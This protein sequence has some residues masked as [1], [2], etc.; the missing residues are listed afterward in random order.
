MDTRE[1]VIGKMQKWA[2]LA[3]G[4]TAL[5]VIALSPSQLGFSIGGLNVTPAD[6]LLFPAFFFAIVSGGF[7]KSRPA[8]ENLVFAALV[9]VSALCGES[10]KDGV[11]EFVQVFLYFIIG[12]R[13][14]AFALE[15]GSAKRTALAV[16]LYLAVGAAVA[17]AAIVQ[18]FAPDPDTFPLLLKSGLGVRG[19]FSNNNVLCGFFALLLPFAFSLALDTK[20]VLLKVALIVLVLAGLFTMLSGPALFAVAAVMTATA[21]RKCKIIG[22]VTAASLLA[23]FFFVAPE[24]PRDNFTATIQSAEIYHSDSGEVQYSETGVLTHTAGTPTRRYPEWQA[25]LMMSFEKP[26]TGIGPGTYQ[27]N[28]GPFYDVI[29]RETGPNEPDVQ[30]LYLVMVSTMGYPVLIAFLLLLYAGWNSGRASDSA[31]SRA[32]AAAVAAFAV[33]AI[34]HPLLVRGIGL[35]L[36]FMLVLARRRSA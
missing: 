28:I 26:L 19:T 16:G 22:A 24:L 5:A 1:T 15:K 4:V 6:I 18:Y 34:W 7:F 35:P 36:I 14:F 10:L 32:A 30:N 11:K 9:A 31:Y 2:G 12:E 8:V 13:V 3:F 17:V 27:K 25:A 33:A 29:P 20:S 21:F 23:L